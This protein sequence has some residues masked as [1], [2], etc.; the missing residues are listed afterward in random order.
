VL[1]EEFY[2]Y[3]VPRPESKNLIDHPQSATS[4]AGLRPKLATFIKA[5]P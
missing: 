5:R 4:I 3:T 1:A 2:D